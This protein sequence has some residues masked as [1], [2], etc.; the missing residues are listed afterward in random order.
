MK[1]PRGCLGG[2]YA[3]EDHVSFLGVC[4]PGGSG[5]TKGDRSRIKRKETRREPRALSLLPHLASGFFGPWRKGPSVFVPARGSRG[6]LG[7]H[8]PG[9][10]S[11]LHFYHNNS[12]INSPAA[13]A[14]AVE[15]CASEGVGHVALPEPREGARSALPPPLPSAG[16]ASSQEIPSAPVAAAKHVLGK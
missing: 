16:A 9:M 15:T 5:E 4:S 2:K 3:W 13:A 11:L 6:L 7:S 1:T 12:L 10:C 14:V 8:G